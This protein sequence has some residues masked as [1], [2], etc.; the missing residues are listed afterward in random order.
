MKRRAKARQPLLVLSLVLSLLAVLLP[1]S[2]CTGAKRIAVEV[3]GTRRIVDT[4][5]NTVREA[6]QA[7]GIVLG[8]LDR[9]QPELWEPITDGMTII[10]TRVR[11]ETEVEKKV[12]PFTRQVMRDEALNEGETRLM[13]LGVNGEEEVTYLVTYEN[14]LEV[15][16][17]PS[18]RRVTVE[19]VD[20]IVVIGV[21]GTLPSVPISGTVTY[22]SNGN[23]WMMRGASGG[24]RP[25]TFTGDLDERVV[26]LSPDGT[27]LL[28][29][30]KPAEE[31]EAGLNSL[32]V[33][34]TVVV[35]D[36]PRSLDIKDV[37][38]AQWSP[39]GTRIAYSTAEKISGRPGWRANNDLWIASADGADKAE[40]LPQSSGGIYGW[41]GSEFA[42]SPDGRVFA[43]ADADEIGV[44]DLST[45]E[46]QTLLEFPAYLTYGDWVW[47][48][49]VSWSP[50][51]HFVVCTAHATSVE[52]TEV[53]AES[54][55]FD[56]WVLGIDGQLKIPLAED[57]GMWASPL[58]SPAQPLPA[59]EEDSR[60]AYCMAE[61]PLDSQAS[62]YDLQLMDRDGSNKS[63]LF[64]LHGEEGLE[65]PELAWSPWGNELVVVR[66]GNLH[67]LNL[68][69]GSLRQLTADGGSSH[70]QWAK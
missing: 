26:T 69:T 15:N 42:W 11:E 9:T 57:A 34:G 18:A 56:V 60:I 59:G 39:D 38:S 37:R 24:K 27:Q 23:A 22:L 44:L 2:G 70:P 48:P 36:E 54:P 50:D 61:N 25:L 4:Q 6:L 47:V 10:V 17:I 64:P 16:R 31:D 35:G 12:L 49:S 14:D 46:T 58:W 13:Q 20:E 55:I 33:V 28:Y 63:K 43:Y 51:G 62:R 29:T 1:L 65:V 5:E 8:S 3:D 67:L 40:I 19:P 66:D 45:G 7:E 53:A 52:E 68:A 21:S 41:W 32:W 30:R